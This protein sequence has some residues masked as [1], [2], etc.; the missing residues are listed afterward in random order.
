M[1]TPAVLTSVWD[2][3]IA[4]LLPLQ[5]T[6]YTVPPLMVWRG[7]PCFTPKSFFLLLQ[8][9]AHYVTQ[10]GNFITLSLYRLAIQEFRAICKRIARAVPYRATDRV[11][12]HYNQH[13]RTWLKTTFQKDWSS[14]CSRINRSFW[15]TRTKCWLWPSIVPLSSMLEAFSLIRSFQWL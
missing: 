14:T 12:V 13:R 6:Q 5:C 1:E 2:L 8:E 9:I 7:K 10:T 4:S 15:H 11:Q 3:A